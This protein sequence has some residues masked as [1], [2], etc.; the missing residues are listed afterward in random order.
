MDGQRSNDGLLWCDADSLCRYL[1]WSQLG[2][3]EGFW[4]AFTGDAWEQVT[5]EMD[6]DL[7]MGLFK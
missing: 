4:V 2:L 6:E 7:H 5:A 3:H 1:G